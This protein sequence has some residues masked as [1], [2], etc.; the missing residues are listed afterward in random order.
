MG[1]VDDAGPPRFELTNAN[2]RRSHSLSLSA[3]V[4]SSITS[5][6][7]RSASARAISISWRTRER[8]RS[9]ALPDRRRAPT[10]PAF[11]S[12]LSRRAGDRSGRAPASCP[13]SRLSVDA[14]GADQRQLLMDRGDPRARGVLR[15]AEAS[16]R[17]VRPAFRRSSPSSRRTGCGSKCS[18]R[19]RF[20]PPRRGP[21]RGRRRN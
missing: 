5:T 8:Q 9:T 3:L 15:A 19:R 20:R 2:N 11:P 7:A 10:P 4:G 21:R 17:A 16:C 6:R 14:H 18:C 1:D 13:S 12:A